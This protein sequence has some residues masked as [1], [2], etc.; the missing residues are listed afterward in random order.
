ML[1]NNVINQIAAGE[2]IE[3]PAS[4]VKELVENSIDAYADDITLSIKS[5][6]IEEIIVKDNGIGMTKEELKMA[7]VRHA[8]SKVFTTDDLSKIA[9]LGFRGEA[10]PSIAAVST[11]EAKSKVGNN[12][13]G[14]KLNFE[15]GNLVKE[16]VV[17][18][19]TGTEIKVKNLFEKIPARKKFIGSPRGE[20]QRIT[21]IF[22]NLAFS[23]PHISFSYYRDENLIVR[24]LGDGKFKNSVAVILGN[25]YSKNSIPVGY[26]EDKYKVTGLI[27]K[28]TF[29]QGS[30]TKQFFF[31]NSRAIEDGSI[32]HALEYAYGNLVP[33]GRFPFALLFIKL[34]LEEID[35]NV[36]PSKKE[37]RF[38][39][40]KYIHSLVVKAVKSALIN[41]NKATSV[42]FSKSKNKRVDQ[43][44]DNSL[45]NKE[46]NDTHKQR[47]IKYRKLDYSKNSKDYEVREN[48]D[49]T[50][51][52]P[53][54]DQSNMKLTKVFD[55][56][57]ILGQI[58][59]SFIAFQNKN[60]LAL[61]DQH[62]AHERIIYDK[63]HKRKDSW[64]NQK[65]AVPMKISFSNLISDIIRDYISELAKV[66]F[67]I[68][69][70]GRNSFIIRSIPSFLI[71]KL[72]NNELK[73]ILSDIFN[74][75]TKIQDWYEK[76]LIDISC[77]AAI[78]IKQN[79]NN[80][81]IFKLMQDLSLSDNW[82]Y[83][84][85]GRPTVLEISFNELEKMFKRT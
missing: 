6:G 2:V 9:T 30:R 65:F 17:A 54:S 71:N 34:P 63:L 70:F 78:K 29:H 18:T 22:Q 41:H 85:H 53:L 31:A 43:T 77:K 81:E 39:E 24:T 32:V 28:P 80:E 72:N 38:S 57:S 35:V 75:E 62:A 45:V 51:S 44:T 73:E 21:G 66:G 7:F 14:Y 49:L 47:E 82:Q 84:P 20:S 61:I 27:S 23:H 1:P 3:R 52:E 10:L 16:D 42:D 19:K 60:G 67:E 79:L 76:L 74:N 64:Y 11:V 83:C 59:N 58:H 36:H 25:E 26:V 8:T 15:Y 56:I 55:N 50:H 12:I 69:N 46:Y 48:I 37:V 40:K 4:I 33:N 5:G 13:Q 68:E